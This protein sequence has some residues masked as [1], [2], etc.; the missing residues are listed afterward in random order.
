MKTAVASCLDVNDIKGSSG[1]VAA[2]QLGQVR[3]PT[4]LSRSGDVMQDD[5]RPRRGPATG[6]PPVHKL[7]EIKRLL[8]GQ[9]VHRLGLLEKVMTVKKVIRIGTLCSGTESPV[10]GID[11]VS[12]GMISPLLY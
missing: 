4:V 2:N 8:V 9:A 7:D 1:A 12:D 5:L 6:L 11:Y 10:L 3:L